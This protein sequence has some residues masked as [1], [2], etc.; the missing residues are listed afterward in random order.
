MKHIIILGDGMA[1]E[2]IS[3]LGG[4]T[5]LEVAHTPNMRRIA[6]LGR[7]GLLH[8]VPKGFTPGSEIA[9]L[10][11]LGYDL[12][13]VFEGRGSLEAASMGVKINPGEM[14]MRCNIIT[15]HDGIIK[16]H[17]GGHIS[18]REA[19]ELIEFLTKELAAS[20][21]IMG[22]LPVKFFPGVSYRHLMKIKEGDKRLEC[23][24]PHDVPG[25]VVSK[26]MIRATA[27]EARPTADMLNRLIL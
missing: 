9:N 5:P 22:D 14:A 3:S 17:S 15:V 11:V 10:S 2:P 16:N 1:D 7:S 26:H 6:R 27:K 23:T 18:T 21:E 24:P 19:A 25:Q 12:R 13:K 20:P 8:T 4:Q